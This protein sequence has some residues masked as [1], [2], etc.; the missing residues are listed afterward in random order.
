[1]SL[2]SEIL[3]TYIS[4]C[5]TIVCNITP[6][7]STFLISVKESTINHKPLSINLISVLNAAYAYHASYGSSYGFKK[8]QFQYIELWNDMQHCSRVNW[9]TYRRC[10]RNRWAWFPLQQRSNQIQRSDFCSNISTSKELHFVPKI[11]RTRWSA[12]DNV[13]LT[14][15]Y[16]KLNQ[17]PG[18]G[19]GVY[20]VLTISFSCT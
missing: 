19:K 20:R 2:S 12:N 13:Q 14:D 16:H 9:D 17:D 7:L 3:F 1:M 11:Y 6:C 5:I 8:S 4:Y 15:H 10:F 18:A